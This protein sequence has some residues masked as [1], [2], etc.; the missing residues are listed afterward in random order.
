MDITSIIIILQLHNAVDTVYWIDI[1][2][3]TMNL[4]SPEIIRMS[5]LFVVA[6]LEASLPT[7]LRKLNQMR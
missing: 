3:F 7:R 4:I 1:K 2:A 6:D 5:P